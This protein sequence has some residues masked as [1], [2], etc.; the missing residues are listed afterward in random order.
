MIQAGP[1]LAA[2]LWHSAGDDWLS[3]DTETGETSLLSGL[4]HFVIEQ[5]KADAAA[6]SRETLI[7]RV[8]AEEPEFSRLECDEAVSQAVRA[9]QRAR[10][11][12]LAD[13]TIATV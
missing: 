7:D 11:L 8:H 3:Y 10:L 9:L 5:I 12:T 4:A 1:A 6:L 2:A 13:D